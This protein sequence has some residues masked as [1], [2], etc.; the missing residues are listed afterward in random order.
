[1]SEQ[2]PVVAI[3]GLG[4]IGASVGL[5]LTTAAVTSQVVGHDKDSAAAGRAKKLGAVDRTD[6]N[7]VS[8]CEKADLVVLAV[9]FVAI[10]ETLQAIGPYL[11]PGCVVVD[12]ATVKAPV[13][14]WAAQFLPEQV[15]F[16]GLDPILTSPSPAE[17]EFPSARADLFQNGLVCVMPASRANSEAVKLAID[18]VTI[19][20][21][22]PLF[23]D[24][25][26]HDGLQAAVEHLPAVLALALLE[27]LTTQPAWLEARKLA[28]PAFLASTQAAQ[29]E[30]DALGEMLFA[31]RDNAV[32][33]IDALLD[34]LSSLRDLLATGEAP[35]L[36][37]RLDKAQKE[38]NK[39]LQQRAAGTW[40][41]GLQPE[42]PAKQSMF[43]PLLGGLWPRKPKKGTK[44]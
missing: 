31:N 26:E 29:A 33:W 20:G 41:L 44:S 17:G 12:T 24:P 3:V 9:P 35:A 5:A 1:V 28:G 4:L 14:D 43:Q 16:V 23:C 11:R 30:P 27:T 15:H 38:R 18:L 19:L 22:K 39:W 36:A 7:L 32:R 25:R 13:F 42:L 8:A 34:T 2:K 6:W 10:K 37:G 21:A 40:E